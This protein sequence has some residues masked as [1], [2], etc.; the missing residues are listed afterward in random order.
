[1]QTELKR[2]LNAIKRRNKRV[3]AD[4]AW[5]TSKTRRALLALTTYALSLI[6][7][8]MINAPNPELTAFVPA[9]AYLLSTPTLPF[10]KRWWIKHLYRR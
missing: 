7:L 6:V 10:F 5:E 1:M 9:V 4:K 2:E 8:V 3:E